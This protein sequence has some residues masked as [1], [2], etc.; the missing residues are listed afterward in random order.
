MRGIYTNRQTQN[1]VSDVVYV[2]VQPARE[3]TLAKMV[4][5]TSGQSEEEDYARIDHYDFGT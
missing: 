3:A 4:R 5:S 1:V 2:I